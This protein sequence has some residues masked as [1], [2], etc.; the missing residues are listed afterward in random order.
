MRHDSSR[1]VP[2]RYRVVTRDPDGNVDDRTVATW[3]GPEGARR[4]ATGHH[5]PESRV[6]Q[7]VDLGEVAADERGVLRPE[8]SDLV[9]RMEW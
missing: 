7:I 5:G 4:I 1:A 2:R 6:E 3:D 8:R 9:D